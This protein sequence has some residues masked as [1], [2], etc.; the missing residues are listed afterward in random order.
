MI[1]LP[2]SVAEYLSHFGMVLCNATLHLSDF[3]IILCNATQHL[4]DFRKVL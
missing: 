2:R 3:G 4:T 1:I